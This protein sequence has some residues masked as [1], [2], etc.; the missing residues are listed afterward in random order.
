MIK[1]IKV[2]L[3]FLLFT[4]HLNASDT[5]YICI[6]DKFDIINQNGKVITEEKITMGSNKFKLIVNKE[7]YGKPTAVSYYKNSRKGFRLKSIAPNIQTKAEWIQDDKLKFENNEM[8][9]TFSKG[10]SPRVYLIS[11]STT[12]DIQRAWFNCIEK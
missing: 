3:L 8:A 2:L 5:T 10:T 1:K 9:I 7:W 11:K 6:M 12:K 4:E